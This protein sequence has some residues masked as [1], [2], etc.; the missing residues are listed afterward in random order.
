MSEDDSIVLYDFAAAALRTANET[1]D[2]DF[3]ESPGVYIAR[4]EKVQLLL[5]SAIEATAISGNAEMAQSIAEV[6]SRAQ[7]NNNFGDLQMGDVSDA[8]VQA[9]G[10]NSRLVRRRGRDSDAGDETWDAANNNKV[11]DRID[12]EAA[13]AV[14]EDFGLVQA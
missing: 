7:Q 12:Q 9:T 13:A 5:T 2:L 11:V 14:E 8:L 6:T 4:R 3:D 10:T 1:M